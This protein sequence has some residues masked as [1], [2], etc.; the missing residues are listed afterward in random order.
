[1]S[2][3]LPQ[4]D[5]VQGPAI[6]PCGFQVRLFVDVAVLQEQAEL[7]LDSLW[8]DRNG[9]GLIISSNGRRWREAG[10]IPGLA[11]SIGAFSVLCIMR[12]SK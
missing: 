2:V 10:A 5:D 9:F 3:F 4:M 12:V 8:R 7:V 11:C 1:M 6:M